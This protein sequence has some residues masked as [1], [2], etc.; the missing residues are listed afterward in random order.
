MLLLI[1]IKLN[2]LPFLVMKS[3]FYYMAHITENLAYVLKFQV[4]PM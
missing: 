1:S 4:F 2:I 3:S